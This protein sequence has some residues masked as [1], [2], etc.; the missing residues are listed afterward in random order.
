M[1]IGFN[2]TLSDTHDMV[3]RLIAE[4]HVDYCELLI[5]NFLCVPPAEIRK[6][7]DCPFGF[8]IMFSEFI[9]MDLEELA[10]MGKRLRVYIDELNPLY[11]SDHGACFTHRGRQLFHLGELDYQAD[12]ERV[13]D[14]VEIWQRMLGRQLLIENYPSMLEGGHDAPRFFERLMKETGA[15]VLFDASNAVCAKHNCGAALDAWDQVIAANRHYHVAGYSRASTPPHVVHDSHSEELAADT[16]DFLTRR[17]AIFDK[18]GATMTYERDGNIE[19]DDIVVDLAR[20]REIFS[21]PQE[22]AHDAFVSECS[23]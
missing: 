18:P 8:H 9:D 5:D 21:K 20:L 17:R 19:F 10:D 7:F 12:Y 14:R 3:R 23:H 22:A 2:F 13:R 16:I 15:G 6:H 4:R 1:Q 11:V